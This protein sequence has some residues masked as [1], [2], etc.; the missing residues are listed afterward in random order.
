MLPIKQRIRLSGLALRGREVLLVE[1]RSPNTGLSR[2]T[3]PG[4]GLELTD[5]D[6]FRGVEREMWEETGLRVRAGAVRFINEFFD[7]VN[8]TL[9]ID[10]WIECRPAEGGE[11]GELSLD[12]QQ[13]DDYI[14]DVQWWEKEAFLHPERRANGALLH[15]LF[16][17]H[18]H[19]PAGP[20]VYLGRWED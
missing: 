10:V 9:M 2:W 19:Q 1:Q 8:R 18:L 4:G 6:I 14:T 15:P 5:A 16:W 12:F 3:T 17:E 7:T 13:H 11:F 20:V